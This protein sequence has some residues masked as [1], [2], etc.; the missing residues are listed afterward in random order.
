MIY[1]KEQKNGLNLMKNTELMDNSYFNILDD[2]REHK[3]SQ[4]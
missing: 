1:I 2:I 3:W 4:F